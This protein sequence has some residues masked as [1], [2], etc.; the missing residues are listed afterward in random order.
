M[1][2]APILLLLA[3]C[4]P[5]PSPVLVNRMPASELLQPCE[6]PPIPS[7]KPTAAEAA[8]DWVNSVKIALDCKAKDDALIQF[9]TKP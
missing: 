7:A 6:T 2:L 9:V 8:T 1:R 5:T 4:S 3:S